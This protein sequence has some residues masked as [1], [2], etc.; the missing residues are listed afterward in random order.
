MENYLHVIPQ[1][2]IRSPPQN[3]K[4]DRSPAQMRAKRGRAIIMVTALSDGVPIE[5][6]L[7]SIQLLGMGQHRKGALIDRPAIDLETR[8]ILRRLET[9]EGF[10]CG[11]WRRYRCKSGSE[12]KRGREWS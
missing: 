8:V 4:I 10:R 12:R 2:R 7:A 5:L 9:A 11:G 1:H 6:N 3:R